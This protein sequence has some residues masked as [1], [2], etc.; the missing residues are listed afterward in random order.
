MIKVMVCH[1]LVHGTLLDRRDETVS[2]TPKF[3][4]ARACGVL[5][6]CYYCMYNKVYCNKL[7]D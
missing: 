7:I 1:S 4:E 3:P 6:G 5:S 2:V